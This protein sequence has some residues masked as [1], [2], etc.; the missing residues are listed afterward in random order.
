MRLIISIWGTFIYE[1]ECKKD[2]SF[3]YEIGFDFFDETVWCS[4]ACIRTYNF[5][6]VYD[7]Q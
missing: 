7:E 2:Y 1:S 5:K 4:V 3:G 6:T